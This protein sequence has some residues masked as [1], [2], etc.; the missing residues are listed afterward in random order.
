MRL[1]IV[2]YVPPFFSTHHENTRTHETEGGGRGGRTHAHLSGPNHTPEGLPLL[3]FPPRPPRFSSL[4]SSPIRRHARNP[5][6]SSMRA[7]E[8]HQEVSRRQGGRQLCHCQRLGRNHE[9]WTAF[10]NV[11]D[12]RVSRTELERQGNTMADHRREAFGISGQ[13]PL[14]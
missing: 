4:P 6:R 5:G 13:R 14:R 7:S 9:E 3:T 8:V 1:R 2:V 10:S 11:H 12:N